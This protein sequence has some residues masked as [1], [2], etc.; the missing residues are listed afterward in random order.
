MNFF[1]LALSALAAVPLN[2]KITRCDAVQECQ[3]HFELRQIQFKSDKYVQVNNYFQNVGDKLVKIK[4]LSFE[5]GRVLKINKQ[6]GQIV[7]DCKAGG[8]EEFFIE[9][10]ELANQ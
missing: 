8:D 10:A 9:C 7:S 4:E 1:V 6:L 2:Y 3:S 5:D